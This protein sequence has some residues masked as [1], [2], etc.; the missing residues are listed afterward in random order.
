VAEICTALAA[1]LAD[2]YR[3]RP[4]TFLNPHGRQPGSGSPVVLE[5]SQGERRRRIT[6][7]H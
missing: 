2:C 5:G 4:R 3:G 6:Q 1:E 7:R